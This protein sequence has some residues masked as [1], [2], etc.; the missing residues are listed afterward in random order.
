VKAFYEFSVLHIFHCISE[1]KLTLIWP[2]FTGTMNQLQFTLYSFS[3][4]L[5]II[6]YYNFSFHLF[7]GADP[8]CK[9]NNRVHSVYCFL[10]FRQ[11]KNPANQQINWIQSRGRLQFTRHKTPRLSTSTLYGDVTT[12]WRH[13]CC[14]STWR[15]FFWPSEVM[16]EVGNAWKTTSPRW[17]SGEWRQLSYLTSPTKISQIHANHVSTEIRKYT[18]SFK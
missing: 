7:S 16:Q 10:F 4:H 1:K 15:S 5:V 6:S 13:R 9:P 18:Y 11:H 17:Y 3:P 2:T 12:S 8:R 14:P